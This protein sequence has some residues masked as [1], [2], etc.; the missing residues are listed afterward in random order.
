MVVMAGVLVRHVATLVCRH[1]M[2]RVLGGIAGSEIGADPRQRSERGNY[3]RDK[4]ERRQY[5]TPTRAL[6]PPASG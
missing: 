5:S 3:E 2:M 4:R 1:P 6:R